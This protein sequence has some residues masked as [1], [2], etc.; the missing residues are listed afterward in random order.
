MS[1]TTM[2]QETQTVSPARAASSGAIA[3]LGGGL[4]FGIM[5]AMMGMLPMVGMLVRQENAFIGFIVHMFISAVIGALYGIVASRLPH[6]YLVGV[7]AGAVNGV[8]WWILGALTMMPILLGMNQMVFVIGGTQW[9]SL[10]GHIIFGVV[11]GLLFVPL[12]RRS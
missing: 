11:T 3:G 1:T 7:F 9:M 5:M 8:I 10:L 4:V 2:Q 6:T 12:S